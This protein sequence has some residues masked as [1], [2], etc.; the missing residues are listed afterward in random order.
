MILTVDVGNSEIAVGGFE[1][2]QLLFVARLTTNTRQTDDEY[3]M[4][5]EGVLRLH[6]IDRA[7]I[8]GVIISSVVPQL[9]SVIKR[10]KWSNGMN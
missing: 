3:S 1:N 9:N 7:Q 6:H 2:D 4:K 10:L 8:S 5:I